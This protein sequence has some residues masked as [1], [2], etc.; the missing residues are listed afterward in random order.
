MVATDT[1]IDFG[2]GPEDLETPSGN[3]REA[4]QITGLLRPGGTVIGQH[5]ECRVAQPFPDIPAGGCLGEAGC[6]PLGGLGRRPW[7]LE[8][9]LAGVGVHELQGAIQTLP[10]LFQFRPGISLA[11]QQDGRFVIMRRG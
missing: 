1:A 4:G 7:L 6:I 11:P 3:G 5:G 8:V 9:H 10:Q 2:L